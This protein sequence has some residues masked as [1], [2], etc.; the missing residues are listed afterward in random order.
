M[1]AELKN[2]APR[3]ANAGI[4]LLMALL[5][6]AMLLRV[7]SINKESFW[8][9]EGWTMLLS[10]GPSLSDVVITMANDQHPP[11]YFALFHYWTLLAGNSESVARLF[12]AFWSLTGVALVYRL[13]AD[14]F[15]RRAG[16]F[17]AL[18]LALADNDIM[19]AQETRHYTQMATMAVLSTI[20]Y[21]RYVRGPTRVNGIGWLLASVALLYTHYLGGF[22]VIVQALHIVLVV[23]PL[24]RWPD[25]WLRWALIGVA[26]LPWAVVF[27]NQSLVRYTRPILFQSSLSNSPETFITIRDNLF[28]SHFGLTVGLLLLGLAFVRYQNG[29]AAIRLRPIRA[30]VY[31]LLWFAVPI[32]AIVA[33]NTRYEILTP[34]NFLLITPAIAVLIGHGLTNLE[35]TPRAFLLAVIVA[36]S[37]TTLDAYFVKPPWRQVAHDIVDYRLPDEPV[38]MDVWVDDFALRYHIGRDL[39]VDPAT[40]PLISIPA[41]L[42]T[43]RDQFFFR[44]LD[45]FQNKS[46]VWIA[47]WGKDEDGVLTF[48]SDH[49]FVRTA[50]QIETHLE[51]NLIRIYRYDKPITTPPLVT[52]GG[53]VALAKA[54]YSATVMR[55]ET[56]PISLWWSVLTDPQRDYSV[57]AFLIDSTGRLAVQ[58]DGSPFDGKS[59]MS[60]WHAGDLHF[61]QPRL[62]IPADLPPGDYRLGLK[63]YWYAYPLPL[64]FT[65]MG[66]SGDFPILGTI[67]VK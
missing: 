36:V 42:E 50:T 23:R 38:I 1:Q 31:L 5:L 12:S 30:T 34:R 28:G 63:V 39:A 7:W 47:D 25:L 17:A 55:G 24:R 65:G 51:T 53:L 40:L 22:I 46:A 48:L 35:R 54:Q 9:D 16:V 64:P 56:L 3:R 60:G 20:F 52:Y 33:I 44:M 41:W 37:L 18:M 27:V 11:L 6:G 29:F 43:Y 32:V 15:S 49:G 58:H 21:L 2:N 13:G 66:M 62:L 14:V 57:S 59:P 67:N 19:L 45:Y 26:W 4:I 8:A 61:D 10:H